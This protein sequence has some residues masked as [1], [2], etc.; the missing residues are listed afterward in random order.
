MRTVGL[1]TL[2]NKLSKYVRLAL[3]EYE[4]WNLVHARASPRGSAAL[5]KC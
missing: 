2:K 3:L 1:K 4:V 5:P